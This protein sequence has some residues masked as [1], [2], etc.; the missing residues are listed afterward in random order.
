MDARE[1]G[2]AGRALA[3]RCPYRAASQIEAFEFP[4]GLPLRP[5]PRGAQTWAVLTGA[6]RAF[7]GIMRNFSRA[8]PT[9]E[10]GSSRRDGVHRDPRNGARGDPPP[11]PGG[12]RAA[13]Q[14]DPPEFVKAGCLPGGTARVTPRRTFLDQRSRTPLDRLLICLAVVAH[15][16]EPLVHDCALCFPPLD[17][18]RRYNPPFSSKVSATTAALSPQIVV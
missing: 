5:R 4:A 1:P 14:K 2:T 18:P 13:I 11:Q 17:H 7:V 16:V 15:S 10:K 8:V 9:R 3:A 6:E 12:V